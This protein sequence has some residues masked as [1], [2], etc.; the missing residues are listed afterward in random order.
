MWNL[1]R[2][3]R[4]SSVGGLTIE[5]APRT[6]QPQV[7][8]PL[9]SRKKKA[10]LSLMTAAVVLALLVTIR[11]VSLHE[12]RGSDSG[13]PQLNSKNA[14]SAIKG[15]AIEKLD[16]PS[17]AAVSPAKAQRSGIALSDK[18]G[19]LG[20]LNRAMQAQDTE[21]LNGPFTTEI[22]NKQAE[23]SE[24]MRDVNVR[25]SLDSTTTGG[26]RKKSV[27]V[28]R[29]M[30]DR[31]TRYL[32]SGDSIESLWGAVQR[33]SLAAERALAERFARGDGVA[34]NCDQAKVLLK[35]AANR[36]SREARLRLDELETGGCR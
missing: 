11:F 24:S 4:S 31:R 8:A 30:R 21:R 25:A 15:T 6:G 35:A 9:R 13:L 5:M 26:E 33:G 34:M 36:G 20:D 12:G 18:R 14:G 10:K 28:H 27:L 16:K 23:T 2:P 17:R 32:N 22:R 3:S 29:V 19:E 7:Y 1:I